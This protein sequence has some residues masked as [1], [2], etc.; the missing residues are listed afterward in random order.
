MPGVFSSYAIAIA[1]VPPSIGQDARRAGASRCTASILGTDSMSSAGA[2][3]RPSIRQR[4]RKP[5]WQAVE[6][7]AR[8]V[9]VVCVFRQALTG[10]E[11]HQLGDGVPAEQMGAQLGALLDDFFGLHAVVHPLAEAHGD[12]SHRS[13]LRREQVRRERP[14][15]NRTRRR[16]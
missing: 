8:D 15:A 16:R 3:R 10:R 2:Y 14:A 12:R 11:K 7:V 13:G 9:R 5:V 1:G 6:N 4:P